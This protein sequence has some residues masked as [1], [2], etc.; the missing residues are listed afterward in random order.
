QLEKLVQHTRAKRT[1]GL[2]R[3]LQ[4]KRV[5]KARRGFTITFGEQETR[6]RNQLILFPNNL[7]RSPRLFKLHEDLGRIAFHVVGV[8]KQ[9]DRHVEIGRI[10]TE[11]NTQ[12][13]SVGAKSIVFLKKVVKV[14]GTLSGP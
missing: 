11:S 6:Y 12:F 1:S 14:F 2:E 3:A 13:M 9:A 8:M 5:E 4:V 7:S 10:T